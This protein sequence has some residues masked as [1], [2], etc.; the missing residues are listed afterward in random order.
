MGK[1]LTVKLG[2][3]PGE[4]VDQRF[5]GRRAGKSRGRQGDETCRQAETS[6][7]YKHDVTSS[8]T[9]ADFLSAGAYHRCQ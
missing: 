7:Q 1:D 5:V 8:G 4:A 9:A 6:K 2:R 3:C